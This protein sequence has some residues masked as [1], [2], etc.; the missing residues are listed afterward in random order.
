MWSGCRARPVLAALVLALAFASVR[1]DAGPPA[2]GADPPD[3]GFLEFLGSVDRLA[4][5][6][7]DYISQ[8]EKAKP[9]V[10]PA[11]QLPPPPAPAPTPPPRPS[12]P[13]TTAANAIA[14]QNN[15]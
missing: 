13:P 7:P 8:A 3:P 15:D 12:A 4:D 11:V 6:N 5:V 2:G 9:G 10:K 1:A 14:G